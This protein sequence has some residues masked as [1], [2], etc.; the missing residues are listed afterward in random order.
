VSGLLQADAMGTAIESHRRHKP[1]CMGTLYW[2]LNDMWPV[3]SWSTI[4]F[5]N[6]PKASHFAVH[7]CYKNILLS[8]TYEKN[9]LKVYLIS[10]EMKDIN[11]TLQMQIRDFDGR[12]IWEKAEPIQAFANQSNEVFSIDISQLKNMIKNKSFFHASFISN[13]KV[14]DEKTQYFVSP[15][16]LLLE[17]ATIKMSI[18]NNMITLLSDKLAKNVFLNVHDGENNFRENYFDLLPG[19]S[20]NIIFTSENKQLKSTDLT[21]ISLIDSYNP[22]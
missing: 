17:K 6:R 12:I 5:Y 15:K 3:V 4:D 18:Q 8:S 11:G 9:K 7:R 14:M 19:K 10:D 22:H 1:H 2:Q 13:G 20:K 21:I 16:E